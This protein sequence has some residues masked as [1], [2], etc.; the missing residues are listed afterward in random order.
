ME[1]LISESE[2]VKMRQLAEKDNFFLPCP[3][4]P[5]QQAYLL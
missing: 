3:S 1:L 4:G 5:V 2:N